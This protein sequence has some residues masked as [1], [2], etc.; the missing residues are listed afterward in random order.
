MAVSPQNQTHVRVINTPIG[1]IEKKLLLWLAA[2][3]PAWVTPDLLTGVGLFASVWIFASYALTYFDRGFLWLASVGF[4]IQWF[5]D[6]MDG[7]L[8]RYRKIERPRYGFFIDHII[9]SVSEVLVFIGLGISPYLRFDLALVALVSY[10]LASIYVYLTTYVEGVF[11]ISYGGLGPTEMRLIAI[12]TN[13]I[14]FFTG[15]PSVSIP[16]AGL[17]PQPLVVTIYDLVVA[18]IVVIILGLFTAS[19][20]TTAMQLSRED[21]EANRLKRQ[22]ERERR[23][24]LR[25]SRREERRKKA[26]MADPGNQ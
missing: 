3:M 19:A 11:R 7:T 12:A 13:T 18:G 5:G 15:N 9:D 6:S 24:A 8:A 17:L 16:T 26:R 23:L 10:L 20:V 21:R 2:R 4:I 25:Q 14:V 22:A 1:R